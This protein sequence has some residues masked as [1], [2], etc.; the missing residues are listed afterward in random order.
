MEEIP[1][2]ILMQARE[3][4]IDAFKKVYDSASN[5]VYNVAFGITG[6]NEEAEEITQ[7]V[8]LKIYHNLKGFR[9]RS[10]IKT[11]IYRIAVNTA[12]NAS[13]RKTRQSER[14]LQY[15]EDILQG[16]HASKLEERIERE[17][18]EVFVRKL[19]DRLRPEHRAC[20]ILRDI[21]GLSYKE[22]AET[23]NININTVRSRL[24][25]ARM[26]LLKVIQKKR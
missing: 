8:F 15:K 23:L 20:V 18:D 16:T 19:L 22:I 6:N 13:K 3:G 11:W 1:R 2:D 5:F 10:N 21:E 25:R 7:E 14:T 9:F 17:E 4:D 24:K 12:I 26:S